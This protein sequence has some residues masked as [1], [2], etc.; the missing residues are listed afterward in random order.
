MLPVAAQVPEPAADAGVVHKP[1]ARASNADETMYDIRTRAMVHSFESAR[2]CEPLPSPGPTRW[3]PHRGPSAT[4]SWATPVEGPPSRCDSS[5]LT[6]ASGPAR[7]WSRPD[8]PQPSAL[9][10]AGASS[11]PIGWAPGAGSGL[12]PGQ[13][14]RS[15]WLVASSTKWTARSP[16]FTARPKRA[17]APGGVCHAAGRRGP[18]PRHCCAFRRPVTGLDDVAHRMRCA[19]RSY[20]AD[21]SEVVQCRRGSRSLTDYGPRSSRSGYGARGIPAEGR[22]QTVWLSTGSCT[23]GR[24][25]GRTGTGSPVITERRTSV[26]T[27]ACAHLAVGAPHACL[28]E[29]LVPPWI[30]T[31]W[32][33]PVTALRK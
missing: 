16:G 18:Q 4:W 5:A 11:S 32:T 29:L 21:S 9:R 19:T 14:S 25:D 24:H 20:L 22:S 10:G 7:R 15:N 1:V 28:R 2:G 12:L 30:A 27:G 8:A 23:S 6:P 33:R 26:I 17:P 3:P 13:C 31:R